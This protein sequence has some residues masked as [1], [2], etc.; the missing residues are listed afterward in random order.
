MTPEEISL[1]DPCFIEAE[2]NNK[3]ILM[4]HLESPGDKFLIF[5]RGLP[6][7]FTKCKQK[8]F[9]ILRVDIINDL[10]HFSSY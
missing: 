5:N 3:Q 9:L 8:L 4:Q 1:V 6:T 10:T 7:F 2:L